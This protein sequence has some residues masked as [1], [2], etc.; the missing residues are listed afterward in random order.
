MLPACGGRRQLRN[1]PAPMVILA[2]GEN[3]LAGH[4]ALGLE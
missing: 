2:V 4:G 1:P 3:R